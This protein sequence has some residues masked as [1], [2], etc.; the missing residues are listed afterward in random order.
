VDGNVATAW[1]GGAGAPLVLDLGYHREFGGLRLRW[2]GAPPVYDVELSSD[3]RAWSAIEARAARAADSDWL[4]LPDAEARFVRIAPHAPAALAEVSIEPLEF[5]ASDNGFVA[6]IAAAS[7]RGL[8]PRGFAGEQN[9]WTLVAPPAGGR[10]ALIDESGAIEF[11]QGG[12]SVEPFVV[13]GDR[14]VTWADVPARQSLREGDLPIPSVEWE[15]PGWRLTTTAIATPGWLAGRYRLTNTGAQ[16]RTLTLLLATRPFQVNPPQQVL[17]A[18]GGVSP[19]R[20]LRRDGAPLLVDGHAVMPDPAPDDVRLAAFATGM[21]P[22]ALARA[23]AGPVD[24]PSGLASGALVY[25]F[26]LRPGETR[27]VTLGSPSDAGTSFDERRAEDMAARQWRGALD[28]VAFHGPPVAEA[29]F[30]TLRSALAQILMS[31][32]GPALRPGTRSYARSWIRDGTMMAEALLRLGHPDA[33]A[34]FLD[35]YAAHQYPDGKMPCCVDARGADPVPENDSDGEFIHLA[36]EI[37]R[38]APDPARARRI[39]PRVRA[40]AAHIEALRRRTADPRYAGLLPPSIS[41]EGYSSRP[42]Y[43]YWD[44]FWGLTGL[45]DAAWLAGEAGDA[46]A[47]RGLAAQADDFRRAILASLVRSQA[48]HRIDFIPGAAD[49]G[50]FDATSTTIALSVAGL[51]DVL[52]AASVTATFDRYWREFVARRDGARWDAYTPYEWRNVGAFVRLGWRRRSG[53]LFDFFMA[54]RR[55]AAWNQW[56]EVVGREPRRPRFVGDMPHGWVASDYINALLDM[57]AY[58]RSDG[59]LV[60]GAGVPDAWLA[61]RGIRVERLRTPYGRL[62]LSL[63]AQGSALRVAWRLDGRAPPGGLVLG[64][65]GGHRLG[66]L[67]GE[68]RFPIPLQ[69]DQHGAGGV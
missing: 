26:T 15:G 2:Q 8:F 16:P 61:D 56:A 37:Q 69:P 17:G 6:A 46:E 51:G 4:R 68:A 62:D 24:D 63:R 54:G 25:R 5:G 67:S 66:G 47:A 14:L 7:P 42:A 33:A 65:A 18:P 32:D 57:I 36:A 60:L 48:A 31:R 13:D 55:P 45:D 30:A 52:P 19:I 43:S 21:L 53:A 59:A 58:A 38:F 34:A 28:R 9:Y 27:T 12:F 11:G 1:R 29:A 64:L 35:W 10:G 3:G 22:E 39:W 49:L 40:A 23:G 41:H 44:D 20:S 50:D